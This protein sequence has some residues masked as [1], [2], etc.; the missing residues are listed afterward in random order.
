MADFAA[1]ATRLET[2][3]MAANIMVIYGGSLGEM[4]G[5]ERCPCAVVAVP[6]VVVVVAV[7]LGGCC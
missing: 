2:V 6:R 3:E 5:K 7:S 4:A 1:R